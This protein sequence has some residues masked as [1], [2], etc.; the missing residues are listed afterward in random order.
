MCTYLKNISKRA[1]DELEQEVTKKQKV[2]DVQEI[3]KVDN[4]QEATKIKELMEIVPDKEEVAID[5]I[6]LAVKPPS[7]ID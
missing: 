7:I 2:D 5:A 6:P 1:G 4:D 3:A